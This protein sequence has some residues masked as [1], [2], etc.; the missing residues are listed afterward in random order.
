MLLL[1]P[2]RLEIALVRCRTERIYRSRR[3]FQLVSVPAS[4]TEF[5]GRGNIPETI[6]GDEFL[7]RISP[8]R[9]NMLRVWGR[10]LAATFLAWVGFPRDVR[11]AE[12]AAV[13]L[14][15]PRGQ[16][17]RR[18]GRPATRWS[19]R[20]LKSAVDFCT[21]TVWLNEQAACDFH[22]LGTDSNPSTHG[23]CKQGPNPSLCRQKRPRSC[24]D[25]LRAGDRAG[26]RNYPHTI[27][28]SAEPA[29]ESRLRI[30]GSSQ[31]G[32]M[33]GGTVWDIQ[34]RPNINVFD[35]Y[36][37]WSEAKAG[38]PKTRLPPFELPTALKLSSC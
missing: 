20:R 2:K 12:I 32:S 11:A 29:A 30:G 7:L 21:A 13:D 5:P 24:R 27:R 9:R 34:H 36:N 23:C 17:V 28:S 3:R 37:Q 10:A 8:P 26:R 14:G 18:P 35:E 16:A 4:A 19:R 1:G 31:F 15:R 25:R 38:Q 6:P 22:E 33:S